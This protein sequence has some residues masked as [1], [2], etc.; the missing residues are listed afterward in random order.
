MLPDILYLL[1]YWTAETGMGSFKADNGKASWR[2]DM[3]MGSLSA[4]RDKGSFRGLPSD[5]TVV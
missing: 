3:E 2:A 4:A 5:V 1:G